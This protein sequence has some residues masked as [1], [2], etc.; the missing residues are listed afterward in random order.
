[1]RPIVLC[2]MILALCGCGSTQKVAPTVT[3][4][5]EIRAADSATVTAKTETK[6]TTIATQDTGPKAKEVAG[7][8]VQQSFRPERE[9][10]A[11]VGDGRAVGRVGADMESRPGLVQ[12]DADGP[13]CSGDRLRPAGR[14][15]ACVGTWRIRTAQLKGSLMGA[16]IREIVVVLVALA[17]WTVLGGLLGK[18][19]A[20]VQARID[21]LIAA[22]KASATK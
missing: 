4:Q 1:M 11:P 14:D 17:I 12:P 8:Q 16:V 19:W 10:S 3:V 2:L 7:D 22:W 18:V 15:P 21:K 5:P 9:S 6:T 20:P 13:A